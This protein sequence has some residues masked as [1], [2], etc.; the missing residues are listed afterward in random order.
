MTRRMLDITNR[1]PEAMFIS[2]SQLVILITGREV[3]MLKK[4]NRANPVRD[5]TPEIKLITPAITGIGEVFIWDAPLPYIQWNYRFKVL[6]PR[7]SFLPVSMR[8]TSIS[9][10]PKPFSQERILPIK[11]AT[12][13]ANL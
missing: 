9:P 11:V 10:L 5:K 4:K 12:K 1:M 3:A 6:I 13:T 8:R 7:F 2:K